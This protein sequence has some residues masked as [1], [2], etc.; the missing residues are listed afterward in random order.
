MLTALSYLLR[1]NAAMQSAKAYEGTHSFSRS[2]WLG[3][4]QEAELG[5]SSFRIS[6]DVS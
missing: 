5:I 4:L 6:R 2:Q 1:C 3:G